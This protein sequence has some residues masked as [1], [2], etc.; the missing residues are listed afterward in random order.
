MPQ[1]TTLKPIREID[2]GDVLAEDVL[3]RSGKVVLARGTLLESAQVSALADLHVF[4]VRVSKGALPKDRD[5]A[6][7][8][9]P[10]EIDRMFQPH[11]SDPLM[12]ALHRA[13][14]AHHDAR[15]KGGGGK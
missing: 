15:R 9:D 13:A 14:L 8:P 5:L 3:D 6:R 12:A 1:Q 4:T 10:A 7:T 11:M 2:P